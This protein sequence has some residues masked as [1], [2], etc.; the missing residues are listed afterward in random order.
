MG[1]GVGIRQVGYFDCAGGGQVVVENGVAYVGHMRSPYGTS[2]IDVADPR[3]PKELATLA[4]PQGAHSH[5]VRVGNGLMLVNHEANHADDRPLPADFRGGLGR[6]RLF[7]RFR[8]TARKYASRLMV[9]ALA[10]PDIHLL[11][12]APKSSCRRLSLCS[13]PVPKQ[14]EG[15]LGSVISFAQSANGGTWQPAHGSSCFL[16]RQFLCCP[17]LSL[18]GTQYRSWKARFRFDLLHDI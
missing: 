18:L 14:S 6:E 2:I 7:Y 1:S 11:P 5:K 17:S 3:N 12:Q 16:R 8:V 4:M 15:N 13:L 9:P 10:E